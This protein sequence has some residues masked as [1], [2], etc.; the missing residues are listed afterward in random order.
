METLFPQT[1]SLT[2]YPGSEGSGE[3][4]GSSTPPAY[5]EHHLVSML[6]GCDRIKGSLWFLTVKLLDLK[7]QLVVGGHK[8]Y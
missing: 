7:Y 5:L 2:E 3:S 8:L 6:D 4:R 1:R